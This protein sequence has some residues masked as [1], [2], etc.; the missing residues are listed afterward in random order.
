MKYPIYSI[1][2][3]KV[4]FMMPQADQN[5]ASAIRGFSFAINNSD[6]IMGFSPNDY[7]LYKIGEF[8]SDKGKLIT[9][10][11]DLIV[12]GSSLVGAK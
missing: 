6:S 1:K 8:D 5:D 10:V 9:Q 11:P 4:G 7:D 12:S 2:D 3:N